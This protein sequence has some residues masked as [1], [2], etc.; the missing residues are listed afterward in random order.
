M[1]PPKWVRF[2]RFP[3]VQQDR[4][5]LRVMLQ[6]PN[7]FLPA[8]TRMTD[9]ADLPLQ[10]VY[11]FL[12]M[13]KYTTE[14]VTCGEI[15]CLPRKGPREAKGTNGTTDVDG[16]SS[17]RYNSGAYGIHGVREQIQPNRITRRISHAVVCY[18]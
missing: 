10:L 18:A 13:N 7:E 8:I 3:M 12:S 11:L 6:N 4:F 16:P 2:P 15:W 9:D 5:D 17:A 1:I 14:N